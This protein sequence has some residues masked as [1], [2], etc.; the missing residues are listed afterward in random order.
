V[1]YAMLA[2]QSD[3]IKTCLNTFTTSRGQTRQKISYINITTHT[4]S[5][6]G[7]TYGQLLTNPNIIQL[8][9]NTTPLRY[10]QTKGLTSK[11][12]E[13]IDWATTILT[14][15]DILTAYEE[16]LQESKEEQQ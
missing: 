5:V 3:P 6:L 1:A 2:T 11:P 9:A 12:I 4:R 7:R 10:T 8:E 14:H 16:G 13:K 15:P